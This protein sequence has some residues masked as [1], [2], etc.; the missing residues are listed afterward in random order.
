MVTSRR[1]N[2]IFLCL[3]LLCLALLASSASAERIYPSAAGDGTA[4]LRWQFGNWFESY[5]NTQTILEAFYF[6]WDG[7]TLENR[8]V[9][10]IPISSLASSGFTFTYHFRVYDGESDSSAPAYLCA[11]HYQEDGTVTS[12]DYYLGNDQKLIDLGSTTGWRSV[13]VT[14]YVTTQLT[15]GFSYAVF[16]FI[17][18]TSSWVSVSALESQGWGSYIEVT[19]VPEP[20]G[21]LALFAGVSGLGGMIIRR[22]R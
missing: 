17:P 12:D 4:D 11:G 8:A 5:Q 9:I 18:T 22:R 2:T 3:A 15:S 6:T 19:P 13:D 1:S 21:L 7:N 14:S 20:S 16:K 10:E